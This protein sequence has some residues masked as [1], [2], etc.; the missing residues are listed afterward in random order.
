MLTGDG[1][2][3]TELRVLEADV[4]HFNLSEARGVWADTTDMWDGVVVCYDATDENA[5]VHV[6]DLLRKSVR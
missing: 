6:E 2:E 3:V 4:S 5:L 1:D